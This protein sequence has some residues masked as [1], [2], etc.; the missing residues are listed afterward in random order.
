LAD[1]DITGVLEKVLADIDHW[2]FSGLENTP[3]GLQV[4][5]LFEALLNDFFAPERLEITEKNRRELAVNQCTMLS[6]IA[7]PET[8]FLADN[9]AKAC[10]TVL[11]KMNEDDRIIIFGSFYTVADA[12]KYFSINQNTLRLKS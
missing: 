2:C 10:D 4:D 8:V 7:Q 11:S 1:K 5:A 9:V 6:N 12:M 3:R